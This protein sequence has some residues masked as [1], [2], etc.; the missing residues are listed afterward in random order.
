M[1]RFK[2]EGWSAVPDLCTHLSHSCAH[3]LTKM[4]EQMMSCVHEIAFRKLDVVC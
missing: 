1:S 3:E 4:W 2:E